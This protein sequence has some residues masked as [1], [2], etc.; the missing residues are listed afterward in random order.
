MAQKESQHREIVDEL[1]AELSQTKRQLDDLTALS[2]DQ[3][4]SPII[5]SFT[6]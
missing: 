1:N 2:R 3:V 4:L 6:C 5:P